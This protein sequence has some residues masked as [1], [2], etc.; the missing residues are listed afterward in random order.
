MNI[1]ID[2]FNKWAVLNKDESMACGHSSS[3]N[4]MLSLLKKNTALLNSF[5]TFMDLVCGNGWVVREILQNDY[6]IKAV[7]VDGAKNM[8]KKAKKYKMGSFTTAD[9]E[10]YKFTLKF[11]IIFSME[12]FYYFSSPLKV[13]ENIV[14]HGLKNNGICIIGIDHFK[15]NQPSL[16]WGKDYNLDLTTLS[17]KEWLEL[18][19]HNGFKKIDYT[20]N[21]YRN[22]NKTLIIYGLK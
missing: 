18:F 15:E 4:V 22:K 16:T 8:I 10:T 14:N 2:T 3:V 1:N 6:C 17:I 5:F 12:T 11:D 21:E 19:K 9:I 20:I 13:L 7:G